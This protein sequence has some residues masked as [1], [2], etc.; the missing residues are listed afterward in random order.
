[1]KKPILIVIII[2]SFLDSGCKKTGSQ[3]TSFT[4]GYNVYIS[5]TADDKAV[6]W[7][8]GNQFDL[9][10]NANTTAISV[11]GTDV[12]V[13][14]TL[15][16]GYNNFQAVYWKNG[17]EAQLSGFN[18]LALGIAQSGSD[19]YCVGYKFGTNSDTAVYWKNGL[20][21]YLA[22]YSSAEALSIAFSGSDMYITGIA[23][24]QVND[25]SICWKNGVPIISTTSGGMFYNVAVY[26]NDVYIV[27]YLSN[28][29]AGYYKNLV[30]TTF[31]QGTALGSIAFSG[32][33]VFTGGFTGPTG[34]TK[35]AYWK[36]GVQTILSNDYLFSGVTGIA[37]A[38]ND[39]YAIGFV[40]DGSADIPVYW[41]NGAMTNLANGGNTTAIC[42]VKE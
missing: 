35:A 25:T 20:L 3:T 27:G 8:N 33:D 11:T 15:T 9:D 21:N 6:Y 26:D 14:G 7:K 24:G 23:Y 10:S 39:I 22:P 37:V 4:P 16:V 30:P 29:I 32:T 38:G 36:N 40:Y 12:Y 42:V 13:S 5:G 28:G 19:L 41:K 17:Q 1:M 18:S 31:P 34:Q 2:Y